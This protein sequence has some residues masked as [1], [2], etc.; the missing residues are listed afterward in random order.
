MDSGSTDTRRAWCTLLRASS[1]GPAR[2]RALVARA[3]SP[4]A[5]LEGGPALWREC[6][7]PEEAHAELRA[8]DRARLDADL[9]WLARPG[10]H[11]LAFDDADF[12]PLLAQTCDAPPVLFVEAEPA[13]LWQAQLAIVGA[14][15]AT[16][17]GLANARTFGT[18]LARAGFAITSGL[19][20]G[21]DGA[22]HRAALAAGGT[23]I[24]VC[25]TGL[26]VVYPKR[27]AALAREV[28]AHG[29]LVSEFPLDTGARAD[30]FPRRNR[31]IAALALGTIVVEAGLQSGS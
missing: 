9:E 29:A 26:E 27:H 20:D 15:S 25:G 4:V 16:A 28:A 22:A 12:L 19:A 11:L 31:I 7:L 17:G 6:R 2:V 10:R 8:P 24:A 30:Q 14:R 5:A 21:I 18:E 3:G 13:L 1:L 23:T